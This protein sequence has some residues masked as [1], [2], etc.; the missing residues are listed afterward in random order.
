M[1]FWIQAWLLLD[2]EHVPTFLDRDIRAERKEEV[3]TCLTM[4]FYPF[5]DCQQGTARDIF[6]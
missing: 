4:S 6:F 2:L 5:V 3:S 1:S